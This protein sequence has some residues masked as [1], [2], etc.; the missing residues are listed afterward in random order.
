VLGCASTLVAALIIVAGAPA[1][2]PAAA[3]TL[4]PPVV[5]V[6]VDPSTLP[7]VTVAPEVAALNSE[8]AAGGAG[9]LAV[10]LAEDLR[11]EAEAMRKADPSLLRAADEGERLSQMERRVEVATTRGEF[12]VPGYSFESLHLVVVFTDG[13]QGGASLGF[14]ARGSLEEVTLDE[15]GAELLRKSSP[16]ESLFVLRQGA[17]G[18]W[19]IA[20]EA[21][22]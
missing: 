2:Q 7:P 22:V 3:A 13:S 11:I 16:F 18:R 20:A 21:R 14:E 5:A 19:L 17:G 15:S 9:Q 8:V 1:R 12:V 4:A 6:E 10:A